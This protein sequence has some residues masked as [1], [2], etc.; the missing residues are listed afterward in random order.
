[1]CDRPSGSTA[2]CPA[3]PTLV[4]RALCAS[5]GLQGAGW[6]HSSADRSAVADEFQIAVRA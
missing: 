6:R 2:I 3:C 1:M 4:R 5:A